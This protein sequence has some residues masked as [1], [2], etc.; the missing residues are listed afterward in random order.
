MVNINLTQLKAMLAKSKADKQ[1]T[2]DAAIVAMSQKQAVM[3]QESEDS[4]DDANEEALLALISSFGI[5]PNRGSDHAAKM[6][7]HVHLDYYTR[8]VLLTSNLATNKGICVSDSGAD[9]IVIGHG[10]IILCN[11]GEPH[12]QRATSIYPSM[13][14]GDNKT[15]R[16]KTNRLNL[17]SHG[18]AILQIGGTFLYFVF[19][20]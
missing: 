3:T 2:P 16:V 15:E 13:K 18:Y 20:I 7:Y 9:C 12:G 6:I 4:D 11:K 10:W 8:L 1:S 19:Q 14:G 5:D 17:K